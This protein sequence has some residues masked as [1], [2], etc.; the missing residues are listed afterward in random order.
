MRT[1]PSMPTAIFPALEGKIVLITGACRGIGRAIAE[2]FG[3]QKSHLMLVDI[4]EGVEQT[5]AEISSTHDTK[6]N[7]LL[8][9]VTDPAR[10]KEVVDATV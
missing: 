4:V 6:V 1:E 5:A 3:K 9:D 8:A 7:F 2:E 10:V